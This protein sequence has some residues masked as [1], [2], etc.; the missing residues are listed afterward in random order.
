MTRGTTPRKEAYTVFQKL[1]N[2]SFLKKKIVYGSNTPT[3]VPTAAGAAPP[4]L[5]L[6]LHGEQAERG[7]AQRLSKRVTRRNS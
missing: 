3:T 4:R 7:A 5:L 6:L 2:S 1:Y